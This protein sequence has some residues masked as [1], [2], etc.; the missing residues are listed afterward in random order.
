VS[1]GVE[2]SFIEALHTQPF[3]G[4]SDQILLRLGIGGRC[5]QLR[6]D[7]LIQDVRAAASTA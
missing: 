7:R 3:L 5:Q 1:G 4:S 6:L 2:R